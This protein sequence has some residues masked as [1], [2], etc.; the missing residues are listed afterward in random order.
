MR[1]FWWRGGSTTERFHVCNQDPNMPYAKSKIQAFIEHLH[2]R[3]VTSIE[4][5]SYTFK[6]CAER[7][8]LRNRL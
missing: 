8:Q 1:Q 5:I 3:S 7:L 4:G 2:Q 6:H